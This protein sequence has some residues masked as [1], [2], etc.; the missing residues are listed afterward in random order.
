MQWHKIRHIK[1]IV[2]YTFTYFL[3][4]PYMSVCTN[5]L[6]NEWFIETRMNGNNIFPSPLLYIIQPLPRDR[7][8][9]NQRE[10]K[11]LC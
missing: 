9:Q 8:L 2:G 5:T 10:K 7:A 3:V 6:W 4:N 11:T 1:I